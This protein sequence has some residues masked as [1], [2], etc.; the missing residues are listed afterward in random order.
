MNIKQKLFKYIG[1]SLAI[2]ILLPLII[3]I[4][5][6]AI[7][8]ISIINWIIENSKQNRYI[9]WDICFKKLFTAVVLEW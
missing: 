1:I 2:T 8:P 7:L 4:T 6:F 5:V 9:K 3:F